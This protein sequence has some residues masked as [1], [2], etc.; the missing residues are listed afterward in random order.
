M[1]IP[2]IALEMPELRPLLRSPRL[3]FYTQQLQTLMETERA[4]RERFYEEISE[5]QKVEFING[6]VIVHSPVRFCHTLVGKHLLALLDVYV[7]KHNLGFVGHEKMLVTLTRNDYEPDICYF[8]PA[9]AQHFT[10]QQIKFPA[11]DMVVEILSPATEANDRGVKFEDYA[12]HDVGEY[13]IIDP[14]EEFVEQYIL[15]EGK[16]ELAVKARTGE[17]ESA[18]LPGFVIPVRALF[19]EQVQFAALQAMMTA[20]V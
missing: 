10:S 15:Q 4:R 16:Y 1:S 9:K 20:S 19:D 14:E 3:P 8:A 5:E 13:W 2:A 7:R 18:V 17:L 12:L 11:P 6:E